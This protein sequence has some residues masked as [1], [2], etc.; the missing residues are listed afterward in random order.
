MHV[1]RALS[2]RPIDQCAKA[3]G[4]DCTLRTEFASTARQVHRVAMI[5]NAVSTVPRF[6][7]RTS[8]KMEF[9]VHRAARENSHRSVMTHANRV[10]LACWALL[11]HA[12]KPAVC[13]DVQTRQL[14]WMAGA[15]MLP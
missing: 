11:V 4:K 5:A 14:R 8:V 2:H 15:A 9:Y 1:A 3:V 7:R 12:L 6:D 13:L 10:Q